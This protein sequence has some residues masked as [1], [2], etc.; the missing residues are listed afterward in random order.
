[1]GVPTPARQAVRAA[2]EKTLLLRAELMGSPAA[3][4]SFLPGRTQHFLWL[5]INGSSSTS[6]A[7]PASHW[8]QRMPQAAALIPELVANLFC[9]PHA[10][11]LSHS[12]ICWRGFNIYPP[13]L[14]LFVLNLPGTQEYVYLQPGELKGSF[15]VLKQLWFSHK[16]LSYAHLLP[17]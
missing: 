13:L 10:H 1:M 15:R 2:E 12:W 9:L 16:S 4:V 11:T 8:R 6:T 14:K 7:Q 17:Q 5:K 3:A